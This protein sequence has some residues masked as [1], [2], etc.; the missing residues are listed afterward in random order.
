[1]EKK[2]GDFPQAQQSNLQAIFSSSCETGICPINKK[3]NTIKK[4]G[5]A[6]AQAGSA[7][8]CRARGIRGHAVHEGPYMHQPWPWAAA[9][10]TQHRD[11]GALVNSQLPESGEWE[12]ALLACF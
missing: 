8:V 5:L 3:R 12:K 7:L 1:M 10:S 4:T 11:V 6:V 2:S 9:L